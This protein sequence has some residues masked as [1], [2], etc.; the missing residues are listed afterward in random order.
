LERYVPKRDILMEA[1]S[2]TGIGLLL[3]AAITFDASTAFPGVNALLPVTGAALCILGGQARYTG[4]LLR[5]RPIVFIGLVSYSL[6]LI[7]WPVIVF[8]KYYIFRP[9][10]VAD[11]ALLGALSVALSVPL[12][13]YVENR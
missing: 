11:K 2:L 13:I 1:S 5:A 10:G 6:Y 3:Y 8:Y 9:L 7:H 4:S 12:Y